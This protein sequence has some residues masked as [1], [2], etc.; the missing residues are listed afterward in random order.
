MS[1]LANGHTD[2]LPV[3]GDPDATVTFRATATWEDERRLSRTSREI[4]ATHDEADRGWHFRCARTL[5]MIERWTLV[6]HEG[7][8]L[9]LTPETLASGIN[10][11]VAGWLDEEAERRYEGRTEDEEGP[12]DTSSPQPSTATT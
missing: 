1:Y 3:P 6:D 7:E 5:L 8:P 2:T 4:V 11:R 12:F 10:R 9:P